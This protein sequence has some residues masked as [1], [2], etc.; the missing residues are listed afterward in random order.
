MSSDKNTSFAPSPRTRNTVP[1]YCQACNGKPIDPRTRNDHAKISIVPEESTNP[2]S[3]NPMFFP[4]DLMDIGVKDPRKQESH[5]EI[6]YSFLV[7]RRMPI[8]SQ[9][10]RKIKISIPEAISELF[11]DDDGDDTS[12]DDKRDFEDD[13]LEYSSDDSDEDFQVNFGAPEMELEG[14]DLKGAKKGFND[15]FS[16]IVIWILKYQGRFRL[17]NVATNSLF[18]FFRYVLINVEK[19]IFSAFPTSLYMAQKNLDIRPHLI[20]YARCE[21]CCKLYK[22]TDVSS[23]NPNI[24]P[25]FTKC[26][27]KEFPNHPLSNKRNACGNILYKLVHTKNGII[28]KPI[29]IFPTVSLKHQLNLL[30]KRKGFEESCRKWVDRPSDPEILTDIY[31]GRIW[32]TFKDENNSIFFKQNLAD[33]HI[34]IML[35]MDWFQPFEN[36]Q[37]STGAIYAIIC[38]LPQ[39]ERFKLSNILTL[40]LIP[41]PK[42]PKLH[43]LNHYL[44]PLVDQLIELWQ[45]IDLPETFEHPNGKKLKGLL[46]A[47]LAIF[48]R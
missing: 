25:K 29:S 48:L 14:S 18:E 30:F 45:G 22:I 2:S 7:R 38:N 12:E 27:F 17:S 33:T 21:V 47:V 31:D 15:T 9:K 37:Y 43:Q 39:N 41:G 23:D 36:S 16:W 5:E 20:S 3:I 10:K 6:C 28:K 40:A 4:E 42:E 26:D 8:T 1:C 19:K 32:K 24:M 44:A 34:G 13:I 35:N 11:S 46:F